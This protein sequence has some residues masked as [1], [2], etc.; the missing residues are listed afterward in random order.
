MT[1]P[2]SVSVCVCVCVC[3]CVR[4][5]ERE[6][7]RESFRHPAGIIAKKVAKKATKKV[8]KYKRKHLAQGSTACEKDLVRC[9]AGTEILKS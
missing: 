4:E 3:V 6:R 7:E 8:T 1:P 5:R 9:A 2:E